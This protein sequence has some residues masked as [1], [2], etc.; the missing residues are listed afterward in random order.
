MPGLLAMGNEALQN[1][2]AHN[3]SMI[4]PLAPG[5][6]AANQS[7]NDSFLVIEPDDDGYEGDSEH[8]DPNESVIDTSRKK[9]PKVELKLP[10]QQPKEID[11]PQEAQDAVRDSEDEDSDLE[12][13]GSDMRAAAGFN[14]QLQPM[15]PQKKI[16]GWSKFVNFATSFF[17]TVVG[18][19]LGRKNGL[20]VPQRYPAESKE[21]DLCKLKGSSCLLFLRLSWLCSRY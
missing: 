2:L 12:Q 9:K 7:L 11:N 13:V 4:L 16:S 17:G 15:E 6:E 14:F 5:N 20:I 21:G 3:Q 19:T 10:H 1:S 8:E 18:K